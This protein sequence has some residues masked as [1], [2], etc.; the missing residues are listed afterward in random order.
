M[1]KFHENQKFDISPLGLLC[2][3]ILAGHSVQSQRATQQQSQKSQSVGKIKK[4]ICEAQI[5]RKLMNMP[6]SSVTPKIEY[7][8]QLQGHPVS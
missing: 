7:Q 2:S 5:L 4:K 6:R 8:D 3:T 1:C